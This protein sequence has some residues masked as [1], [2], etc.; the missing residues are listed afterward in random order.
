VR[1]LLE[2]KDIQLNSIK[3]SGLSRRNAAEESNHDDLMVYLLGHEAEVPRL[4]DNVALPPLL[5]VTRNGHHECV[6]RLLQRNDVDNDQIDDLGYS[7]LTWAAMKGD[8]A[9][10]KLLLERRVDV[11]IR[12]FNGRTP[13][14]WAV[15][16]GHL[17]VV[18]LLLNEG[19][20]VNL[21]DRE[22]V[23]PISFA[24][25]TADVAVVRLGTKR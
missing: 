11:N 6:K 5:W 14:S 18:A 4:P 2:R 19:V 7:A 21:P 9:T 23:T 16:G 20:D 3:C 13:P 12:D 25:K 17:A 24:A 15:E 8:E 10:V 22:G 1:Q